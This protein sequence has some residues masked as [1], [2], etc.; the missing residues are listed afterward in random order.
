MCTWGANA[1]EGIFGWRPKVVQNLIQLIYVTEY[2]IEDVSEYRRL[3]GISLS[4]LEYGF[5]AKKLCEDASHG[6][7]VNGGCL[8]KK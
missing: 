6:P 1:A 4:A 7:D 2:S 8:S 3:D 5:A